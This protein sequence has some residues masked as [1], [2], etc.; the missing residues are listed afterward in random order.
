MAIDI[1]KMQAKLQNLQNR[2]KDKASSFWRPQDGTQTV[3]ILPLSDGD[4][5]PSY[6]FHYN[7]GEASGFL[8]P[9]QNFGDSCPV[10]DFSKKLYKE[11]DE[12][13]VKMAKDLTA[14]QR[15]FSAV[16][17]RGNESEGPKIWG[18]GKKVYE[19]LLNLVL[20]PEYG[21]ITDTD[22]GTDLDLQ[23]GKP[24]GA[25]FPQTTLTPKRNTTPMCVDLSADECTGI[26]EKIPDTDTLFERKSTED[27]GVLLD[28]FFQSTDEQEKEISTKPEGSVDVETAFNELLSE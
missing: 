15:F 18:Y 14:R 7:V 4:P 25:S 3:R 12:G 28:A 17:V 1:K 22:S 26:L 8:C 27:V 11:G 13:S 23:Y 6:Y 9:K 24:A 5:F 20:N 10:C 19:T 2:G 21:D 16:L